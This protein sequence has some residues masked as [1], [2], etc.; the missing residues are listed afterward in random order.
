MLDKIRVRVIPIINY[1]LIEF[2]LC[3]RHV[4]YSAL[5]ESSICSFLIAKYTLCLTIYSDLL[6]INPALCP[7]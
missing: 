2:F 6:S 3:L 4:P 7:L 1:K 5:K